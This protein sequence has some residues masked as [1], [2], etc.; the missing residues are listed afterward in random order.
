MMKSARGVNVSTHVHDQIDA[1]HI[2]RI[3]G[4]FVIREKIGAGNMLERGTVSET[5]WVTSIQSPAGELGRGRR[6][7]SI[8]PR[9]RSNRSKPAPSHIGPASKRALVRVNH[10]NSIPNSVLDSLTIS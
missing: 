8:Q 3:G 5:G 6:G 1:R 4:H 7:S 10:P 2:Q 9:Q